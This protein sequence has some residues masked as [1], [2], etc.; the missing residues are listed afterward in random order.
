MRDFLDQRP[1]FFDTGLRFECR[2]CG[3]CCTGVPGIIRVGAAESERISE[4][5][6]IGLEWFKQK[7]LFQSGAFQSIREHADGRCLFYENGCKIYPVRPRQ[8]RIY[9]FWFTILRSEQKW[10]EEAKECAGIGK[11][12]LY[13]REEILGMV[14]LDIENR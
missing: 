7:Y 3:V 11:G 12:R 10:R 8:C 6:K 2:R 14:A 13:T 5:L 1:Y 4:F 9:P